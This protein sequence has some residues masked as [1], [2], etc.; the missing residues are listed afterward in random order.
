MTIEMN[1]ITLSVTVLSYNN[2]HYIEECL[3]SI[4]KQGIEHYEVFIVDD[5]STDRSVCVI[6]E[7]IESHPQFVLIEKETNSGGAVSSQI[8]I[9]RST[10]KYCAIVDSDDIVADEIAGK[11][12]AEPAPELCVVLADRDSHKYSTFFYIV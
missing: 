11:P 7:F 2:E 5:C 8:G 9:A 6:N 3:S 1:D 10:G 12:L 4:V